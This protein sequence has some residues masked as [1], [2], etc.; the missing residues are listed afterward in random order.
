[1]VPDSREITLG[2]LTDFGSWWPSPAI[3]NFVA[4]TQAFKLSPGAAENHGGY[5][6]A[7][8]GGRC[9]AKPRSAPRSADAA[10]GVAAGPHARVLQGA[11]RAEV[12]EHASLSAIAPSVLDVRVDH[13]VLGLLAAPH[14]RIAP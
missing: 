4:R 11:V 9:S 2:P 14:R 6:L 7:I 13:M 12:T 1:M 8:C 5:K 10:D 3:Q